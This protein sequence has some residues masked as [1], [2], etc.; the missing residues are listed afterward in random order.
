METKAP[1]RLQIRVDLN[2]CVGS[3][4]CIQLAPNVFGLGPTMQ[5]IV[6]NAEG[7]TVAGIREAAENCP[8]CA[9]ELTDADTGE[10]YF[11]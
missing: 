9:I 2:K 10:T 1:R 11:P 5:S 3:T 4:M 8:L 6:I 7:A